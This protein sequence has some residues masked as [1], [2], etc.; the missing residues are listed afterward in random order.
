MMSHW[1]LSGQIRPWGFAVFYL[2][3]ILK[4]I[5]SPKTAFCSF[6]GGA[7]NASPYVRLANNFPLGL[8]A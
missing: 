4:S 5:Q 7:Q 1:A 6:F 3:N 8:M 2:S